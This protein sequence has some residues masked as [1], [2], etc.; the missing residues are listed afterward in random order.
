MALMFKKLAGFYTFAFIVVLT[1]LFFW[2]ILLTNLILTGVD[3]FLYFYP[4]KS[5]A[6]EVMRQ[7]RLPLWNPHLFMGAPLLANSQVGVFYPLNW[8]LL[9]L[10]APHQIAWSI[11]IH[12][13]LAGV[14]M[15]LFCR[16]SLHMGWPAAFAGGVVFAFGGYLGAQVE[17]INQ[18][19]GAAWLPLLYLLYDRSNGN[20]QPANGCVPTILNTP[21]ANRWSSTLWLAL[22]ITMMLLAGHTQTVFI[23]LF[24][25]GL[26][27][28]WQAIFEMSVTE[29][30]PQ[31]R[32]M[33]KKG[34]TSPGPGLRR[35][36]QENDV[37]RQL[38]SRQPGL[39]IV[40][41]AGVN[42]VTA[43]L[44]V[45]L[46]AVLAVALAAMQLLPTLELSGL[47]IRSEGL[48]FQ[49]V[50]SFSLRPT[51]LHYS[52][53][54]P[55]GLDLTQILGQAFSEWV[56]YIGVT[57]LV[58][59]LLGVIV[60]QTQAA[61]RRF[62]W[63][64]VAG[65]VLSL[66]LFTGPLYVGLYYLVPGFDLFRVPA[67]WLLLYAFSASALTGYGFQAL[68]TPEAT[69]A[70][71]TKFANRFKKVWWWRL[72]IMLPLLALAAL[73]LW[74]TP[75][76][77]TIVAWALLACLASALVFVALRSYS[78]AR[79]LLLL[80]L[81]AE[82]FVAAQPLNYNE[83]TAPQ[84]YS[85]MRN[86][87]AYLRSTFDPAHPDRFLSL[88]GITY[89]PGDLNELEQLFGD[90]LSPTALYNLVV[91]TKQKEVL[92][93]NLPMNYGLH[94]VDGYDGG[95][96]PLKQFITFEK[97]FLAE[98]QLS[99]D[100]RLREKLRFVP[101]N[102]LLSLT[103][104]RWIITDKQFDAW[105]DGIFYDLQFPAVLAEQQVISTTTLPRFEP[106]ALGLVSH[107]EGAAGLPDDAPVARITVTYARGGQDSFE[108]L[109]GRDSAEGVYDPA[110][111]L[112]PQAK[113]GVTWPY[114]QA[115][116]DYIAV[117][118]LP[119]QGQLTEIK[120]ES[121]AATGTFVLRG[122]TLIHQPTTTGRSVL[123]STAGEYRQV[124]SGDVKI[125]E[126]LAVLPRAVV[127]HQMQVVPDEAAAIETL[128]EPA[129]DPAQSIV[130][131][132][133]EAQP[134]PGIETRGTASAKERAMITRYDAETIELQAEL[135]SPGWLLLA[136][137]NYPGWQAT[138]NGQL[139][140]IR[141]ANLLFRAVP[142]PT[143]A[144]NITFEFR[145]ASLRYGMMI[146]GLTLLVVVAGLVIT[147]R[148]G[149]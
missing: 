136:E 11:A 31:Q 98:D 103:N 56:A 104:T 21:P 1:L 101:A 93:F 71:L 8:P 118:T 16:Q 61:P 36:F 81:V 74:K 120:V 125:Y 52:L 35:Y 137:T 37:I 64:G 84:A 32:E 23:S 119:T 110:R 124:H 143:G 140:E 62:I 109:A 126:N 139:V 100:G 149:T 72:I 113:I 58:M 99:I 116:V 105:I 132:A 117:K 51:N 38:I 70:S 45:A 26:Y 128:K 129:F 67:R 133:D 42:L 76:L 18:L 53:L 112:H 19:Q 13:A 121:L 114:D 39:K 29:A 22:V 20:R 46:A 80:L 108:L 60:A 83:P 97:L 3:V 59:A 115:G 111:V 145:P 9:W 7:G 134:A 34:G 147:T 138:V 75:P 96:L 146:T 131:V 4:Y 27:A 12:I 30:A 94:S 91:A 127:V 47:S 33:K 89:D 50:V 14:L 79:S 54:P 78:W 88:S 48:T 144:S 44:P 95:I 43:L 15:V 106:T 63:L 73:I 87:T 41:E 5:Y 77:T 2:K 90:H 142:L 65:L 68:Q 28:V 141:Q 6:A 66:G 55:L 82:L 123:L 69:L 17:H 24:G 107:L 130:T 40:R 85:S 86:A 25:L 49:E 57:G 135:E 122:L 148:R 10:D 102:H 92:F